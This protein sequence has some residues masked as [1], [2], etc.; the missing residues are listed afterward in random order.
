[1]QSQAPYPGVI[2]LNSPKYSQGGNIL[3]QGIPGGPH[4]YAH[5]MYATESFHKNKNQTGPII[6]NTNRPTIADPGMQMYVQ[7]GAGG[8]SS[9]KNSQVVDRRESI[10]IQDL[11]NSR[12]K[13]SSGRAGAQQVRNSMTI[14]LGIREKGQLIVKEG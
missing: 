1:M 12:G 3:S 14:S 6:L 11:D 7:H 9:T 4:A 8:V 5:Q 13:V 2:S 10:D